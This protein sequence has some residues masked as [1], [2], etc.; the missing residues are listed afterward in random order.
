[1]IQFKP[2]FDEPLV[3]FLLH[4]MSKCSFPSRKMHFDLQKH[5][6]VNKI[7]VHV[8]PEIYLLYTEPIIT[9]NLGIT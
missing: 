1:M 8:T 3:H 2:N 9:K 5:Y 7:H 6:S 4:F